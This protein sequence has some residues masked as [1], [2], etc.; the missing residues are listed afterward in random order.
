VNANSRVDD[1]NPTYNISM[2]SAFSHIRD[3]LS[4][5][6]SHSNQKGTINF[7]ANLMSRCAAITINIEIQLVLVV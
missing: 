1:I 6:I 5:N 2:N 4:I 7:N 3:C